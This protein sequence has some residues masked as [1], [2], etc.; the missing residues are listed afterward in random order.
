VWKSDINFLLP[1]IRH[2]TERSRASGKLY[3]RYEI[4]TSISSYSTVF[5]GVLNILERKNWHFDPFCLTF[6]ASSSKNPLSR[7]TRS[8]FSLHN[9]KQSFPHFR[10]EL[11]V[12]ETNFKNTPTLLPCIYHDG[13]NIKPCTDHWQV[14]WDLCILTSPLATNVSKHYTVLCPLVLSAVVQIRPC[15]RFSYTLPLHISR[16]WGFKFELLVVICTW[17]F[18]YGALWPRQNVLK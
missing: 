9:K 8:F 13:S 16:I 3:F 6:L 2:L 4:P 15:R 1:D 11:C 10:T 14:Q 17:N 12:S 5:T 18:L 7:I